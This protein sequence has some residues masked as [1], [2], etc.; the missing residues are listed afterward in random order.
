MEKNNNFNYILHTKCEADFSIYYS[1]GYVVN[2][3]KNTFALKLRLKM[4][5]NVKRI[6]AV[7]P[8]NN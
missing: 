2:Q 6:H 3:Q 7:P 4:D 8:Q 5:K 1:L